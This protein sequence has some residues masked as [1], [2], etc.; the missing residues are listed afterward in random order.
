MSLLESDPGSH[1]WIEGVD[2]CRRLNPR[3][4]T[5]TGESEV[6]MVSVHEGSTKNA[7]IPPRISYGAI[8]SYQQL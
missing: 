4:R 7:K 6:S 8:L 2:L 3:G 5:Q 1:L